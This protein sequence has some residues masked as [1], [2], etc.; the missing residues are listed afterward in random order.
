MNS[1]RLSKML[2]RSKQRAPE[3]TPDPEPSPQ[4]A[5][6]NLHAIRLLAGMD[7]T[8]HET[9]VLQGTCE[10]ELIAVHPCN[11]GRIEF[12]IP[13]RAICGIEIHTAVMTRA[14]FREMVR[15]VEQQFQE[16]DKPAKQVRFVN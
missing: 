12:E 7:R 4:A 10:D 11:G 14:Q 9:K 2:H 3:A 15:W 6:V 16:L 8:I 1:K 5:R 13:P